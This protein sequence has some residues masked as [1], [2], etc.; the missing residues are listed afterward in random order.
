MAKLP[1][2]TFNEIWQKGYEQGK[3]DEHNRI[4]D[5][6]K[7]MQETAQAMMWVESDVACDKI[8]KAIE[9]ENIIIK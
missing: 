2:E 5:T 7:S 1:L 6:I 3:A 8:L 9:K 4:V